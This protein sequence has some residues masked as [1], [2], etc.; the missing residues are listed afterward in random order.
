M[1]TRLVVVEPQQ[2]VGQALANLLRPC[3]GVECLGWFAGLAQARGALGKRGGTILV[4]SVQ[5]PLADG[6]AAIRRWQGQDPAG[7]IL[8]LTERHEPPLV[9]RLLDA[10]AAAVAAKTDPAA[11]FVQAVK[12]LARSPRR[13][14][15]VPR[16]AQ[17]SAPDSAAEAD[18]TNRQ[19]Q[20][21]RAV[22]EGMTSRQMALA[23]G[24]AVKTVEAHR[25]HICRR[26]RV[27]SIAALTKYAVREGLTELGP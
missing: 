1:G 6:V 22:A 19:R 27:R 21:L 25:H 23:F 8:A 13:P 20:I 14:G 3:P 2:L 12:D 15:A 10:G 9:R 4:L 11:R 18:L 5:P 16:S 17:S 26:L 24:I 7:A